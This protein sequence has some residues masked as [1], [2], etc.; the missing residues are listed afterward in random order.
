[1]KLKYFNIF[2]RQKRQNEVKVKR[3]LFFCKVQN[4][5]MTNLKFEYLESEPAVIDGWM[6]KANIKIVTRWQ[7]RFFRLQGRCIFYFKKE[8]GEPPRGKIPLCNVEVRELPCKKGKERGFAIRII[9]NAEIAKRAEYWIK[10]ENEEQKALWTG[11]II[12]NRAFTIMGEKLVESTKVNPTTPDTHLLLPYFFPSLLRALD[13]CKTPGIWVQQPP[14]STLQRFADIIDK[15]MEVPTN[16]PISC[17]GIL[18]HYLS[19]L[20]TSIL[21]ASKILSPS[22]SLK[23]EDVRKMVLEVNAVSREVLKVLGFHWKRLID[24]GKSRLDDMAPIVGTMLVKADSG[25]F[26]PPAQV[27]SIQEQLGRVF[28]SNVVRIM[29]DVHQFLEAPRQGV[30][31][32][33]RLSVAMTNRVSESELDG[34]RGL[35]V[36]VVREDELGWCTVYTS[37]RRVGLVHNAYLNRVATEKSSDRG[38]VDMDVLLDTVRE[39]MPQ[40]MLLFDSM[41]NEAAQMREFLA[42]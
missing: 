4:Q 42:K 36:N 16:D 35:L 33:A 9:R 32:R 41:V 31:R 3:L 14:Q 10:A 18:C 24:T 37:N 1:M 21:P 38:S 20:Q 25:S 12:Q 17:A 30:I 28:L 26:V 13:A 6:E 7:R 15:N 8:F 2:P 23:P 29:E 27:K 39:R 19:T 22:A 11:A 5:T 40:M 34:P